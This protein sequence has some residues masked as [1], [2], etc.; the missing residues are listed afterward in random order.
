MII[1]A[2]RAQA[3]LPV[4]LSAL[5]PQVATHGHEVVIVDSTRLK[6]GQSIHSE[7]P[8]V[9]V[10]SL[11]RQA[12]PGRARNH[13]ASI[14]RGE[15]LAFL[16][17]DAIPEPC[18]LEELERALAP[19]VELVA[20][21]IVNGT[22]HSR[23]G[24]ASYLLEFL[25]WVP[26][27]ESRLRHAAGCNLLIRRTAF[28][29]SG[30]FPDDMRAGED[31]VF[32]VPFALNR[33]LAFAPHARVR[34]LNRVRARAVLANQ[35]QLGAAWPEVC[36][37]VPIPRAALAVPYLAPLAVIERML[38]I[39]KHVFRSPITAGRVARHAPTLLAGLFAWGMG[40]AS[41]GRTVQR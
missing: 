6:L 40:V 8:W 31:T 29:C 23:W 34:H 20:G 33:T 21:A 13:G 28:V 11:E 27:R 37:R 17:A 5:E 22:P 24:T 41:S 2:Y 12:F 16:D 32:S 36:A 3:T 4:V 39:V 30:G 19:G 38:A 7:R 26:E 15:L 1:P 10:M 35:R 25:E 18:W 14:A 9:R